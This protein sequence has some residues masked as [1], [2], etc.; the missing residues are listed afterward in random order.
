MKTLI[1]QTITSVV[2]LSEDL[3]QIVTDKNVY[4]L[5]Q[6][7][8]YLKFSFRPFVSVLGMV[9]DVVVKNTTSSGKDIECV[10]EHIVIT[11][12]GSMILS[13]K[14]ADHNCYVDNIKLNIS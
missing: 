4:H 3:I 2:S 6:T 7:S 10:R 14:S 5:T 11:D 12:A 13:L 9:L 1:G 8:E